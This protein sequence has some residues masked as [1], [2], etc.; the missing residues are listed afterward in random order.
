MYIPILKNRTVEISILRELIDSTLSKK[1]Y[2]MLEIIQM[3]SRKT[4][5]KTYHK[6]LYEIFEKTKQP[7]LLDIPKLTATKSTPAS[8]Q[9]FMIHTKRSDFI[10]EQFTACKNI[11]GLIPVQSFRSDQI[12]SMDQIYSDA[13]A[14]DELYSKKALRI[15]PTQFD[16]LG[17]ENLN[18]LNPSDILIFDIGVSTHAQPAFQE[19]YKDLNKLKEKSITTIIV[20]SNRPQSLYNKDLVDGRPILQIDNSL[21]DAYENYN[22][23]GFGDY[24]CISSN[25]PISGG[26]I[27]PAGIYYSTKDNYFVGYRG[28]APSLSEFESHIAPSIVKSEYW[29]KY[30]SDHQKICPGCRKIKNIVDGKTSGKSQP[31]WK[32]IATS[33]YIYSIDEYMDG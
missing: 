3:K 33:H 20:N 11:P 2:P 13:Y 1:T 8:V 12:L 15:T 10:L 17:T 16:Q 7:F 22:F 19:T 23:C 25:L 6:E 27:S 9:D 5:Q 18:F 26:R 14:L 21:R 32:G 29:R 31:L 4:S 28:E 30:N 24:A